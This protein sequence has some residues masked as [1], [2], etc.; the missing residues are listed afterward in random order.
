MDR[1]SLRHVSKQN[2]DRAL[3]AIAVRD[4]QTTADLLA[5][6]AEAE[7]KRVYADHG[8]SSMLTYCMAELRLSED[9]ALRRIGVARAAR[10]F[11]AIFPA[12]ADGRLNLTSVLLIKPH[13]RPENATELLAAIASR[14]KREIEKLIVERWP[15]AL[16]LERVGRMKV[17]P[18]AP[19]LYEIR[20]VIRQTTLDGLNR[21]RDLM[22]HANPGGDMDVVLDR[23]ARSG[24][25][26]FEKRKF[27]A[28]EHPRATR[29]ATTD[30]RSIPAE[31]RR[32]VYARD[33]GQCSFIDARGRRCES[34]HQL[35]YDHVVPLARGGTST[36][37]NVR[38]LCRAHNQI[39]A[40]DAFGLAFMG[41]KI[42]Q[43]RA[44]RAAGPSRAL[45]PS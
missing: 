9:A 21:S 33:G 7:A 2:L 37:G 12:I 18:I 4:R 25:A 32:A 29:P 27:A 5:H 3:R 26:R 40:I 6:L 15:Q 44:D 38:T 30:T 20:V 24:N 23:L 11:P 1:Y 43:A 45:A 42:E 14:T 28:T 8:Y 35:E 13:L 41:H 19:G 39:A 17:V 31:V 10:R 22:S 36:V 34:R 16:A